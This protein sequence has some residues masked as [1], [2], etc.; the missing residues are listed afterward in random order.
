M[1]LLKCC[2][3]YAN[4]FWKFVGQQ[5]AQAWKKPVFI[6]VPRGN[7]KECSNYYLIALISHASKVTLRI[8]QA[9]LQQHENWELSQVQARFRKGRGTR[10]QTANNYR[11]TEKATEFQKNVHFYFTE[12]AKAFD[13]VDQNKLE[14]SERDGKNRIPY[15]SLQKPVCRLRSNH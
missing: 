9:R 6:P 10:N 1:M 4:K 3:Q 13:F 11:I 12:Y 14:N 5:C 2:T 8:L 7:G 15:L